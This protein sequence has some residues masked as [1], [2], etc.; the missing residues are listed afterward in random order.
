MI[1]S[2]KIFVYNQSTVERAETHELEYHGS[3]ME[4]E[5]VSVNVKSATPIEWHYGDHLY[6]RGVKFEINYDP[7]FIK[8]ARSGSYGEGFTYEN[9]KFYPVSARLNDVAF[10]DVVLPGM[11][12]SANTIPYSMLGTFSFFAGSVED[13]ADRV[14]ANLDR[15]YSGEWRV[16]T[17]VKARVIQRIGNVGAWSNYYNGSGTDIEGKTEINVEC[18]NLS[19]YDALALAYTQFDLSFY[20]KG[21]DIVIGGKPIVADYGFEYGKG[22]GLYE[23]ERTFDESQRIVTKM[24]AYGSDRNLPLNYY[25]NIGKK[26]K[27][28]IRHKTKREIQMGNPELVLWVNTEFTKKLRDAFGPNYEVK[29]TYGTMSARFGVSGDT[30][31]YA[32]EQDDSTLNHTTEYMMF[33]ALSSNTD[34]LTFYNAITA[35][36][37]VYVSGANINQMPDTFI[38]IPTSY[39]YDAALSI[40]KLMLPG[41]PTQSLF[42]WVQSHGATNIDTRDPSRPK[43]TWHGYTAYFS[44]NAADPWIMST[45]VDEIGVREG[46][47]EFD[48]S[49]D[50]E[51]YPSIEGTGYDEVNYAET[52]TDNG[53]IDQELTFELKPNS[54]NG[55]DGGIEWDYSG[56]TVSISMKDGYCVGREFEVEKAKYNS[57]SHLWELTMK[58]E[59]DDSLGVYFPYKSSGNL[60]Q[61]MAGDHFVVLGIPLPSLYVDAAAEKLLEEALKELAKQDHQQFTYLPKIDEIEMARQHDRA[62]AS[63]GQITSVHDTICAGMQ[64]Q[65]DDDDLNVHYT[66]FI[67]NITIKENG[68]NGIPTYDVVLRDE[69]ELTM[70]QRIQSQ[71]QGGKDAILNSLGGEGGEWLSRV[72]DDTAQGMITF[73][74]G[75]QVGERF[76]T[77]LLGEGGVFRVE[78]DGTTYIEAD[79]LYIRMKAYFDSVE[80]REYHHTGGNRIASVAGA[81]CCRVEWLDSRGNVLEK[82]QANLAST[83]KFRCYFMGNDGD[84]EVRNNWM[85]GDLAYC[86]ITTVDTEDDS[87]VAKGLNMKHYW[88]KVVGRNSTGRL[89][90]KGEHYIDLS[91]V[92]GEYQSGSD[93]PEAQDD[94]IQLG[95]VSDTDRQGAIIEFVTGADA[96]SYQI[97]Q[98][99]DS[100]DLTGKNYVR[101]GYDSQN[102]SAQ[103]YIGDPEGSTYLWYHYVTEE[104][105]TFPRLDIKAN[106]TFISP[107]TGEDTTIEDFAEAV[108]RSIS[109]LQE[110]ID[111][112]LDTWYYSGVPTLL[113]VPASTW[114]TDQLKKEHI[115][116]LYYDKDTG[117]VYRFIYDTS[118]EPNEFKWIQIHDDAISEALRIANDAQDTA[119]SKRRVFYTTPTPPYD[120]GDLWVNAVW[121][122]SGEHQGETYN[123]DILRC[124][125]SKPEG[126][127]FAIGDWTLASNYTDD[128][129]LTDFV[130]NT[131]AQDLLAIETQMD[132]KAETWYQDTDPSTAWNDAKEK[133]A[134]VG[135]IWYDTSVN[136]GNKTYI[137]RDRGAG[138]SNRFYWAEQAVP[139]VVFDNI[140]KKAAIYVSWEGWI[141]PATGANELEVRDLLIP[142]QDISVT[143]GDVQYNYYANKVYRCTNAST[144]LFEEI[145]YTDDSALLNFINNTYAQD[146]AGI[147][148]QIDRK[149]ETWYQDEDPSLSTSTPHWTDADENHVGDIW[150]DTS[151]NG[152]KKTYI[153]RDRG[154]GH[155]P[156]YYW[157]EQAVPDVVFDELDGKAAIYVSWNAWIVDGVS[158]LNAKDLF[159]PSQNVD[160]TISGVQFHFYANKVYRCTNPSIPI[161][162]E[163]AYTD[164]SGMNAFI[165][166]YAQDLTGINSNIT[167]AQNTADSAAALAAV[168]E[169]LTQAIGQDTQ[170]IGGLILTTTIGLRDSNNTIWA[171][172]NGAYQT[173]ETGT[174][175]KGHGIAAWYGGRMI[176][177]EVTDINGQAKSL[178]RFDGSGYVAGKNISWDASGNVTI[179]GNVIDATT[180]QMGG[181]NVVTEGALANYYTKTEADERYVTISY[182]NRLFQAYSSETIIDANKVNPNDLTTTISNIKSMV[183]FWTESYLSCLGLNASGGSGGGLDEDAM[184]T[185]LWND[186]GTYGGRQIN[187]SHLTYVLGDYATKAWVQQQISGGGGGGGTVTGISVNNGN[188]ISPVNGIVPLTNIVETTGAT[189]TGTLSITGNSSHLSVGGDIGNS[190]NITSAGNIT[191]ASIIKTGGT[192]AQFLKADGS[193]DS[194]TYLSS[195]PLAATGTIGGIKVKAATAAT[196]TLAAGSTADR[197]YG[198]QIDGNGIAFVNV[199]WTDSGGTDTTNT[200]GLTNLTG[201]KLFLV[202]GSSQTDGIRTYSNSNCYIGTDN[203]LYS[204]GSKVL[205]SGNTVQTIS[206]NGGTPVSPTNGNINI[207]CVTSVTSST[208]TTALGFTPAAASDIPTKVSELTNDSG[209]VT[210]DT[211]NTAGATNLASTK[212]FLIGATAQ[213]DNPVTYSNTNCYIGTDNSLYS[214]G[215]RVLTSAVQTISV[216]SGTPISPTNG[217]VNISC[218][219]TSGTLWGQ[220]FSATGNVSGTI[221]STNFTLYDSSSNPYLNLP[222][223]G[224]NWYV[225]SLSNGIYIGSTSSKS[226][227]VNSSGDVGIGTT[228]PSYKLDVVGNAQFGANSTYKVRIGSSSSTA[229]ISMVDSGGTSRAVFNIY[230]DYLKFG[231]AAIPAVFRGSTIKL[232]YGSS[233]TV[234][235]YMGSDGKV[236]IGTESPSYKLHVGGN[237]GVDSSIECH[238]LTVSTGSGSQGSASIAT[239]LTVGSH[240]YVDKIGNGMTNMRFNSN[241]N[242]G[243]GVNN[244]SGYL[245]QVNGAV[246][247]TSWTNLSD[248][249]QKNYIED[250]NIEL[251]Q[252]ANAPLFKFTWKNKSFGT[253]LHIGSSA[254]YWQTIAPEAVTTDGLGILGLQYDVVAL[255]AAITTAKKVQDHENRIQAL[256]RENAALR[257]ELRQL[258]AA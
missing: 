104:G 119:D 192:S 209:F 12:A 232:Q 123:N 184:W 252:V 131:Y 194:S 230:S 25:A 38:E 141:N 243:I 254:Q 205:T 28:T 234:G 89:T 146:L 27:I 59:K 47:V 37:A 142:S 166:R 156:R 139:D 68:N 242:V 241:G 71:I 82:T 239:D 39:S 171:G 99:I 112:E 93:I 17:P 101:F 116:D 84:D 185:A 57:D 151:A 26:I 109:D 204:N 251:W 69:K 221:T 256:E 161:F 63:Q 70:Q 190:G 237:F 4:D 90:V 217:N 136:G 188:P 62:I 31:T 23:I 88:R 10:K 222:C 250:K 238:D 173:A 11:S 200:A 198:L 58:R 212:L 206:I 126:G 228:S 157:A 152:G 210:S 165:E 199:P 189:M 86:H 7:N 105:V 115:G 225:Q 49:S 83:V 132:K 211:K 44:N 48:S 174:G 113:N 149:A 203:C 80:I 9:I 53:H 223:G 91:N 8:K 56:E 33:W 76:V 60:Y 2:W 177:G 129:A 36:T 67:D 95:N 42:S 98:G 138:Q 181:S 208:V 220:S 35:N 22:N 158:Q 81:R 168:S 148:T 135:D 202:G 159:I 130:T 128:S 32:E 108:D 236:G 45:K 51:I 1:Q 213:N 240:V 145:S 193:V 46:T 6:Y 19:V 78:D 107:I 153:W 224:T 218:L 118:V 163:I 245:L 121:P 16:F 233:S 87:P 226:L 106:V 114:T 244:T 24:Y 164:D 154:A 235:L 77:G 100:F 3:W 201:T 195:V 64:M 253:D 30:Y 170:T 176:D 55:E 150:Y 169:Y 111:G 133:L 229:S 73:L 102:H 15:V 94:I 249:R 175:Y 187:A 186:T 75:L 196:P 66:P 21:K 92:A 258:R 34:A 13:L 214:N 18:Q 20:I 248:M 219:T 5:Y 85:V 54:V 72:N 103:A 147:E 182:F 29:L 124:V 41:F 96:P 110:Q 227:V 246:A 143:I 14:Q 65:I 255:L 172:I 247:G 137:W 197:Y 144:P 160:V 125:T 231:V 257:N 155:S 43:A 215:K 79:K 180:L 122:S 207:N 97:F 127:L 134:H 162:G 183:G 179:R 178:F 61:I 74:R 117:Y 191:G 140:D 216:N 40:M 120:N 50:N 52:I 167:A